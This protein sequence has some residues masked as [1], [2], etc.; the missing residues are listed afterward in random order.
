MLTNVARE[1]SCC[2]H[3]AA[4]LLQRSGAL[5]KSARCGDIYGAKC[6]KKPV[7]CDSSKRNARQYA[8]GGKRE[9]AGRKSNVTSTEKCE[10]FASMRK[11][12]RCLRHVRPPSIAVSGVRPRTFNPRFR[13]ATRLTHPRASSVGEVP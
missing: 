9:R 5:G 4:I 12:T 13:G 3:Y 6:V 2:I 11:R 8:R 10:D 7:F 1:I